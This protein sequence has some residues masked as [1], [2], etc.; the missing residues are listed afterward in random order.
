MLPFKI[1][2]D[3]LKEKKEE[4]Q[5]KENTKK[6]VSLRQQSLANSLVSGQMQQMFPQSN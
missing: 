2:V 5:R 1:D 4:E 6:A 3:K